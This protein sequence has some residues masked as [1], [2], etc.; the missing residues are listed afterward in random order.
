MN[1]YLRNC[2]A[3][4]CLTAGITVTRTPSEPPQARITN[5]IVDVQ[6]Y[7]PDAVNGYYRGTRFDWSGV[8]PRVEYKG[9]T[10]H[11][12]WFES[13][14]PTH[15]DAIMGPVEEFGALGY[16]EGKAGE[17]FVK[18]GVGSLQKP[19]ER[20]Y[21]F[22]R[23]YKIANG[24]RWKVKKKS[25]EV[26]FT[27]TLAD[28]RYAYEYRKTV[29]LLKGKPQLVLMHS[30]T[31]KGSRGMNTTVYNHNF[32]VIDKQLTGPGY[33]ISFPVGNLSAANSKGI[34]QVVKL[35][36]NKILYL[37]GLNKGEQ[38]Y[39]PDLTAGVEMNYDITVEH[40]KT[41]AGVRIKGD[42][43][44]AKMVYWS[45]STTVSPEPYIS[46]KLDPGKTFSWKITYEY[47]TIP[48]KN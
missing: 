22:S 11:G 15:H 47:Y 28:N 13:Y 21:A 41:G 18:I 10:Y 42:R 7:L 26:Q 6:L 14:N 5:G 30:L 4:V 45:S 33:E 3:V 43:P 8:M 19:D 20:Q 35:E 9:H 34:G 16:D 23:F 38:G 12:Q 32:F 17:T 46:I 40:V 48:P 29:K 39:F 27:H 2:C 37:R 36:D 25:D 24:G 44:V 31:N 1:K